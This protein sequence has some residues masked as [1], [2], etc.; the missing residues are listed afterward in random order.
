M[1]TTEKNIYEADKFI[2]LHRHIS[3]VQITDDSSV[4]ALLDPLESAFKRFYGADPYARTYAD[5]YF[6]FSKWMRSKTVYRLQPD[7]I[8][9]MKAASDTKPDISLLQNFNKKSFY[10]PLD[11]KR[12]NSAFVYLEIRG[13]DV[14]VFVTDFNTSNTGGIFGTTGALTIYAGESVQDAAT[15]WTTEVDRSKDRKNQ[16]K[17]ICQMFSLIINAAMY[18]S[19][20][21]E[22]ITEEKVP[23]R[24]RLKSKSGKIINV[25][26]FDVV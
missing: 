1:D 2:S 14:D 12:F 19:A 24:K 20:H 21:P 10:I 23:K 18:I 16:A 3:P 5:I 15:R 11:E 26:Y 17:V 8:K 9:K 13:N 22:R 4:D 7:H 6:V 25:K